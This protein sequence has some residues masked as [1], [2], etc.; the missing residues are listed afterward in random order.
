MQQ[1]TFFS[2]LRLI[3]NFA[4]LACFLLHFST[5]TQQLYLSKVGVFER[6]FEN[7]KFLL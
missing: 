3:N 6:S 2:K 1:I 7:L 4:Q 5:L